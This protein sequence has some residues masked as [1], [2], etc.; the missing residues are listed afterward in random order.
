MSLFACSLLVF[1]RIFRVTHQDIPPNPRIDSCLQKSTNSVNWYEVVSDPL[2]EG[3]SRFNS[4]R[5]LVGHLRQPSQST[6]SRIL[7]MA[8]DRE[9]RAS[10]RLMVKIL[11][12]CS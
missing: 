12:Q 8:N 5:N 9:S 11:T 10:Q 2:A 4:Q 1:A 7:S 3:D 6:T